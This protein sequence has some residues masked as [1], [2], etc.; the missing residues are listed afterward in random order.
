M[1]STDLFLNIRVRPAAN[2]SKLEEVLVIT[3]KEERTAAV[4]QSG[5]RAADIL[6]QRLPSVPDTPA[7][8]PNKPA[9]Q[10]AADGDTAAKPKPATGAPSA[11]GTPANRTS[12][13][14][15]QPDAAPTSRE[16]K[17]Q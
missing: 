5:M 9:G 4:T 10:P 14:R 15:T 16:N 13:T 2:L 8:D 1:R 17:P 7:V 12:G 11:T 6:A 3:Q